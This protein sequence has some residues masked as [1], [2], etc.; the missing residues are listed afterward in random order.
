LANT[1]ANQK[2]LNAANGEY[3]FHHKTLLTHFYSTI[4]FA[5]LNCTGPINPAS[6]KLAFLKSVVQALGNLVI[7]LFICCNPAGNLP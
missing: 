6:I 4:Y 7:L 2:K 3:F 5:H 1:I